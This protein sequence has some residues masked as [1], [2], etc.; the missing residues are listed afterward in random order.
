M[1][2]G[3]V[4]LSPYNNL[5][6]PKTHHRQTVSSS[7]RCIGSPFHFTSFPLVRSV[8]SNCGFDCV[9]V[10]LHHRRKKHQQNK[11]EDARALLA[12]APQYGIETF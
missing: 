12:S 1:W 9:S 3:N 6:D 2:W 8:F 4:I 11:K 10:F 7:Y 5:P